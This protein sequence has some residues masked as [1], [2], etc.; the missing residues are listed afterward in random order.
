[1][2]INAVFNGNSSIKI[3]SCYYFT[4]TCDESNMTTFYN[5]ISSLARHIPKQN[6]LII[7]GDG[8]AQIGKDENN[9]FC[10]D[11]LPDRNGEYLADS[12]LVVFHTKTL[13][14]KKGTESYALPPTQIAL[15][16]NEFI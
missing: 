1:M 9:I 12:S 15:K 11:N 16:Y 5:W 3:F 4:N 13:N 8:N 6:A 2:I 7:G 10:F 14:S